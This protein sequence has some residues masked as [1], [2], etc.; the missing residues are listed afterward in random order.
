LPTLYVVYTM[1]CTFSIS[2]DGG[3]KVSSI[4]PGTYQVEVSTPVNF[5]Y[6]V[7]GGGCSGDGPVQFQLTGPG[8]NFFT[9]LDAGCESHYQ[10]PPTSFMAGSTYTAQDNSQP[11]TTRTAFTTLA[12]GSPLIPKSPYG[13]TSGKGTASTDIVGS[14]IKT[15]FRGTLIGT[16]SA[17][18]KPTLTSNGKIVSALKAGRY[19]FV[20]TDQDPKDSFI[21]KE[22]QTGFTDF[23]PTNLTGVEF[24]GKHSAT[25][26]LKAGQWMYYSRLGNFYHFVVI[27]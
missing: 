14:G 9:T 15:A 3:R 12:S 2:D 26:T 21:L 22:H 18:G 8:V 4:A 17:A 24:V 11:S 20:I 5:G 23:T 19:R 25:V 27:G 6:F 16:L 10:F 1:N 7:D 13:S